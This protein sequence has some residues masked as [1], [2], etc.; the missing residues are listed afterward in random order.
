MNLT[1]AMVFSALAA[2]LAGSAADF[3]LPDPTRPPAAL[4]APVASGEPDAVAAAS[5]P[6]TVQAIKISSRRRTA[7][8]DGQEVSLGGK[9]RDARVIGVTPDEVVLRSGKESQVLKL[10]PDVE[11]RARSA[12]TNE[13]AKPKAK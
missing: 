9:F 2:P 10:Y 1:A 8:I 4:F 7:I 11:K 6:A 5:A 3:P 13:N 12:S